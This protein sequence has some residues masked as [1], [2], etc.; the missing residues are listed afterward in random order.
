MESTGAKYLLSDK[1]GARNYISSIETQ[2][3]LLYRCI[4]RVYETCTPLLPDPGV[5]EMAGSWKFVL[6]RAGRQ[7]RK[8]GGAP[9]EKV[10]DNH[11]MS[12]INCP[13][14]SVASFT[15]L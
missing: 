6:P 12:V 2:I 1:E 5:P 9:C 14:Q 4:A 13:R 8:W 10:L 11:G 3:E 15:Q 7:A